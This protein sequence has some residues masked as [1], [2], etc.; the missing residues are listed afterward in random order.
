MQFSS[1]SSSSSTLIS[2]MFSITLL[3]LYFIHVLHCASVSLH[4]TAALRINH[5][6]FL[7]S[8]SHRKLGLCDNRRLLA[9]PFMVSLRN[10]LCCDGG[11][12]ITKILLSMIFFYVLSSFF[13]R[14]GRM[15]CCLFIVRGMEECVG[16]MENVVIL[17][18]YFS[19]QLSF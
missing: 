2:F 5:R 17:S 18:Q 4:L 14:Y 3:F 11:I 15:L 6:L 13:Q 16:D 8:P 7:A 10:I 19:L 12:N 1:S 9:H